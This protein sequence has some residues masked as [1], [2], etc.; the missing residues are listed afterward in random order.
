MWRLGA[1]VATACS[2]AAC[3]TPYQPMGA[4]GGVDSVRIDETTLQV[5]AR[6]NAYTDA[7][8]IQRYVLRKAAEETLAAGYDLFQIGQEQ[9]RSRV[10]SRGTG[11]AS[12]ADGGAWFAGSGW[13]M[14]KPGQTVLV[15]M[16]RGEKPADAPLGL[17]DAREVLRFMVRSYTPPAPVQ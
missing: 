17:Y 9:D 1:V 8:Q 13:T 6:G 10:G 5:T 4:L 15:R 16:L 14:I 12:G 3:A 11:F 2:L 7:D